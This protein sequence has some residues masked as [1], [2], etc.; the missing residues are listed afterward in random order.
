M[1]YAEIKAVNWSSLRHMITSP[2]LY[3]WRIDNPEPP[4]TTFTLGSAI[5]CAILEPEKL[6]ARYAV[7]D[8]TRRGKAWDE[9]QAE[10]PGVESLKPDEMARVQSVAHAVLS[11]KEASRILRGGRAE[12]VTEW[13]DPETGIKCKGRLDYTR[14]D[15]IVDLKSSRDVDPRRFSRSAAEYSYHGQV[16]FYGDGATVAGKIPGDHPPYI[17]AMQSDEPFDVA[18]YELPQEVIIAGRTLYRALLRRLAVCIETNMWPGAVPDVAL[19][20]LPPWAEGNNAN[21]TTEG[22]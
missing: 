7:F 22:F 15:F 6:D 16:S 9:W 20:D 1:S 4:K 3:R 2:L 21:E 19:L 5:H 12:E 10:H 13:T 11:H 14:P 8:G 17:V 18:V